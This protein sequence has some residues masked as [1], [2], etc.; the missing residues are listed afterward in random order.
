V[1]VPEGQQLAQP[2]ESPMV[3]A[4]V[5]VIMVVVTVIMIIVSMVVRHRGD[6]GAA[7]WDDRMRI[8]MIVVVV[9]VVVVVVPF[10]RHSV[11][12]ACARQDRRA[13]FRSHSASWCIIEEC[14]RQR[15]RRSITVTRP[16]S[17]HRVH[18]TPGGTP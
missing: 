4:V 9:V 13:I 15:Q 10:L 18:L 7:L 3:V 2:A 5:A 8:A 14:S 6:S 12:P 11:P 17:T 1:A 16:A